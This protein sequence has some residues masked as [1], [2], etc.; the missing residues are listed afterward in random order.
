MTEL[1]IIDQDQAR[2]W[3]AEVE[4]LNEDTARLL[5][6]AGE[7]LK[8]LRAEADSPVVDELYG[9]GSQMV[10]ASREILRGMNE[11]SEAISNILKEVNEVLEA[12]K[13][14]VRDIMRGIGDL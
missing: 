13:E 2:V 14:T 4:R 3:Q 11:L 9:W 12:G 7:T 1:E 10:A 8:D 5:S 6:E